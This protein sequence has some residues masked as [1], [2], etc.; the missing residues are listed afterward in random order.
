MVQE[1]HGLRL[2]ARQCLSVTGVTE[3]MRF[4]EAAVVLQ[5]QMGILTV[6]GEELQL[7]E[8]SVEGG[9][10]TVEGTVNALTYEQPRSGG[11]LQR[12]LG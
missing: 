11:W 10:V 8:L 4:E 1:E 9:H 2:T 7:K 5:T 6:L 12:L 3:V